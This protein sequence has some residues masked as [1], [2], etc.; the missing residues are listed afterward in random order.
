MTDIFGWKY[1]HFDIIG[2]TNDEA[3]NYCS[4]LYGKTIIH[5]DQQTAGR[6]RRGRNWV[7]QKGNLF[8]SLVFEYNLQKLGFLVMISAL[9]LAQAVEELSKQTKPQLK[10]PNDVLLNGAKLS[11]IL[12]EKGEG[13]YIIVGIGV[14]IASAPENSELLYRATS[15]KD[16]GINCTAKE[17]LRIYLQ[18]FNYQLNKIAENEITYLRQEWLKRAYGIG[19]SLIVRQE[20]KTEHGVFSGIDDNMALLL[21]QDGKIKKI[22]VGDVFF[23][24]G[25]KNGR[26]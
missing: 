7:S 9:S 2:S 4:G 10:W 3:K 21:E 22:L 14:N 12:L 15:L 19:K 5:A 17:F 26:I 16:N 6:G 24:N 1:V 11:G 8:F 13:N 23:E 20:E 25:D 18:K